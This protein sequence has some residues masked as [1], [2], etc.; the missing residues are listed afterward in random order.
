MVFGQHFQPRKIIKVDHNCAH[1]QTEIDLKMISME[2][3]LLIM[4]G[5]CM[6][7]GFGINR[8]KE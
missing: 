7:G 8:E 1:Q 5:L 6:V 2:I 3:Y 4:N